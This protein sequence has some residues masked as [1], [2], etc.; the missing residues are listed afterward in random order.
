MKQ[1]LMSVV[2][3]QPDKENKTFTA[4]SMLL[5]VSTIYLG[6]RAGNPICFLYI[7]FENNN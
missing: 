7:L 1:L 3:K 6:N 5:D 4:L 2:K